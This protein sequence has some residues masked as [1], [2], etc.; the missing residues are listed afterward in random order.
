MEAV[1]IF[2]QIIEIVILD[3]RLLD[4][5]GGLVALRNLHAIADPAH[6]DL[7]DR[8]SLAGMDVFGG[9]DDVKLAV[10]LDDVALAN[11]AG[12]DFQSC[13]PEFLAF[14]QSGHGRPRGRSGGFGLQH[15]DFAR[16]SQ[17]FA[18]VPVAPPE[19]RRRR[20]VAGFIGQLGRGHLTA[21]A[22]TDGLAQ[23]FKGRAEAQKLSELPWIS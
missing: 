11:R 3:G 20:Y 15:T 12:D 23:I 13:F 9:E 18:T 17:R 22:D 2:V 7:A 21:V 10:L 8:S 5:V 1:G 16:R 14:G 6:F 4:L 19:G